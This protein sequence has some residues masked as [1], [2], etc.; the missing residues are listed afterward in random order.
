[1]QAYSV[2]LRE[3]VLA[4]VAAGQSARGAAARFGIGPAT[5]SRGVRRWR[6]TGERTARKQ[7]HPPGS[8]LDA[9]APYL[10]ELVVTQ[11]DLTRAEVQRRL[12]RERGVRAAIGTLWGFYQQQGLTYKKDRPCAGAAP[13]G[14]QSGLGGLGRA[15]ADVG[16][17]SDSLPG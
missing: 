4:A 12:A 10:L 11:V 3:R 1:M 6:E 15:P 17:H 14:G 13:A 7:G 2:D 8:K 5:A 9:H 16:S